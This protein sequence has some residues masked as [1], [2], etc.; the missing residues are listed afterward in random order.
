MVGTRR[1][2]A[3]GVVVSPVC[4][5]HLVLILWC[6]WGATALGGLACSPSPL[7]YTVPNIDAVLC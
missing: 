7:G 5:F 3:P 1:R 4:V 6:V 2:P